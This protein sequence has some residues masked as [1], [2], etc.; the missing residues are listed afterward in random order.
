MSN[1]VNIIGLFARFKPSCCLENLKN[2]EDAVRAYR[3]NL[4]FKPQI[5]HL[6]F[7]ELAKFTS[8]EPI[9]TYWNQ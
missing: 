4:V 1:Q 8:L 5:E 2:F 3:I 9:G 6:H 7:L